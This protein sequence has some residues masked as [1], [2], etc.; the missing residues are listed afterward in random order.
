MAIELELTDEELGKYSQGMAT[1]N[2]IMMRD[3][4]KAPILQ[5]MFL[6]EL[7]KA[8]KEFPR[9]KAA[10]VAVEKFEAEY[11]KREPPLT[12]AEKQVGREI[13]EGG[14][15]SFDLEENSFSPEVKKN[16][17]LPN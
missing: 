10:L 5:R 8:D 11:F 4:R 17:L 12:E 3:E 14:I 13:V 6:E 1:L 9:E 16:S 15:T 7:E 2:A